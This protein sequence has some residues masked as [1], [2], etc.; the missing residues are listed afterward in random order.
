MNND[1]TY[2]D[3]QYK[4][5]LDPMSD[6]IEMQS[7]YLSRRSG[8]SVDECRAYV[9]QQLKPGGQFEFKDPN[10]AYL[11]REDSKD[12]VKAN[13]TILEY[14]ASARNRN[15]IMVPSW[16]INVPSYVKESLYTGYIDATSKVRAKY[17]KAM[18][19]AEQKENITEI[20]FND[21]MQSSAKTSIN[22]ISGAAL[23]PST[24]NHTQ[25]LHPALTSVCAAS[26]SLA[27]LNN[28]KLIA[29]NRIYTTYQAT[30]D[31]IISIVI[32][33]NL[34]ELQI[35]MDEFELIYPSV[36]DTMECINK[37]TNLYWRDSE[38][39]NKLQML[40]ETLTPLERAAF[41][42]IG[43]MYHLDKHNPRVVSAFLRGFTFR[44]TDVLP[45]EE[46]DEVNNNADS[47]VA[48]LAK[49]IC[50][51][52]LMGTTL[53]DLRDD[54]PEKYGEI[55]ANMVV[56]QNHLKTF[57]SL[58]KG[59]FRPSFLNPGGNRYAIPD[60]LREAVLTSDTDSTI[61]TAQYWV[62]RITGNLGFDDEHYSVGFAISFLVN[63]TVHHQLAMMSKNMGFEDKNLHMISMKNEYYF[64]V[65]AL[66][67]QT[68]NY[69]AF[70]S[71]REGNVYSKMKLEK[72]GVGIR[73]S[74][75]PRNVMD[76]FDKYIRFLMN[77]II[78]VQN[79]TLDEMFDIPY[80]AESMVRDSI[81]EGRSQYFQTAQ[82]KAADSYKAGYDAPAQKLHR[83]WEH[84]FAD[85]YG[86]APAIPYTALKIS[87][88]LTSKKKLDAWINTIEDLELAD[89][90]RLYLKNEARKDVGTM[91]VP[92]VTIGF[93]TI[94]PEIVSIID[95]NK[96]LMNV[97]SP[98]YL[99]L[100]SFGFYLKNPN[101]TTMI[102]TH[103]K[104]RDVIER[105][106]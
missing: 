52:Y 18:F 57:S 77:R 17:K 41:V 100:E 105:V 25:S 76:E 64:P 39:T 71:V 99:T 2:P 22:S 83:L 98:F 15:Y 29:G 12:R 80:R 66:T 47:D 78:E 44:T 106:A 73:S 56:V 20:K 87:T 104:P 36:E 69:F 84:V 62:Q 96:Q 46:A 67:N 49:L 4:R 26:T 58:I 88:G 40:V 38:K 33:A 28:E 16:S 82:I 93:G 35:A 31:N 103:Y 79:I 34:E 81:L 51:E 53:W 94:P 61:Y 65:Y 10:V 63:K 32:R 24:V 70:I 74:K 102:H 30:L 6:Y 60:M 7:F 11:S 101:N 55:C 54:S 23:S 37:S 1:F 89:R 42:Y 75:I 90:M 68:K 85:K 95:V 9:I 43:D 92:Q 59:V 3:D 14:I 8:R 13:T 21:G 86:P 45:L 97:M 50:K 19:I 48:V 72:K 5:E 91:Y 27:N